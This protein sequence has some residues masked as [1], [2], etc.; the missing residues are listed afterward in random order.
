MDKISAAEVGQM[1]KLAASALRALSGRN[2]ELESENGELK[3]KLASY[4]REKHAEKIAMMMESKGIEPTVS[5]EEK[6][7]KLLERDDLRVVEEA[8]TMSSPQMKIAS[9]NE[10]GVTIEGGVDGS[11]EAA[12]A[13]GLATL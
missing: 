12:F 6:I 13:A 2:Q 8:V 11:A 7:A 4:E 10:D 5:K 9:V 3:A 1:T